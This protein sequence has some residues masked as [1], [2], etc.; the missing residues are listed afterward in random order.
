[1]K[2]ASF[3]LQSVRYIVLYDLPYFQLQDTT[4]R[5]Q[6]ARVCDPQTSLSVVIYIKLS[7]TITSEE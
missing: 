2:Y 4:T 3:S 7:I 5:Q 6:S 1:M